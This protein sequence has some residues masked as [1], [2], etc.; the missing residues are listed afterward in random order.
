MVAG[1]GHSFFLDVSGNVVLLGVSLSTLG[2]SSSRA[3]LPGVGLS[4]YGGPR[5]VPL[6]HGSWLPTDRK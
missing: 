3:F 4:Q 1:D 6:L 2:F 5:V